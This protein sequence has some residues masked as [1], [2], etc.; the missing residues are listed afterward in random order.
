MIP[1]PITFSWP[2]SS[3][4]TASTVSIKLDSTGLPLSA[5]VTGA[6]NTTFPSLTAGPISYADTGP[7]P[8]F[9]G[10]LY[11]TLVPATAAD[12][13]FRLRYSNF[14]EWQL[15]PVTS[16][17][18]TIQ[19]YAGGTQLTP[20][21]SMPTAATSFSGKVAAIGFNEGTTA[22][23]EFILST[24]STSIT[25]TVDFA[26]HTFTGTIASMPVT[27]KWTNA[28]AG[29]FNSLTLGGTI[30]GNTFTGTVT[31]VAGLTIDPANF[32]VLLGSVSGTVS[33]K[34]YGP[35]ADEMSGVLKLGP[36][37]TAN[38]WITVTGSFGAKQ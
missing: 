20:T 24:G 7:T 6:V 4:T 13:F 36:T 25:L 22:T 1:G 38:G 12:P 19:E 32:L 23:N 27:E 10:N 15:L 26:L 9:S 35:A 8:E 28:P 37:T 34:F 29:A 17:T 21:A 16:F 30:S 5:V 3:P 11:A 31:T 2:V 14:G 18:Y 33:G